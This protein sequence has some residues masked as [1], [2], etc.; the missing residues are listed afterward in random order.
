[1]ATFGR[2][3]P[4][5]VIEPLM[6][7]PEIGYTALTCTSLRGYPTGTAQSAT[8]RDAARPMP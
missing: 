5:V 2:A 3:A 6:S 4:A 8:R 7:L 1:V